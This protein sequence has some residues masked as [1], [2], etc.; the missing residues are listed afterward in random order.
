MRIILETIDE[1]LYHLTTGAEETVYLI[2]KLY[3]K[4]F[5]QRK[6]K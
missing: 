5:N 3:A 6:K 2:Q 4:I 1:L